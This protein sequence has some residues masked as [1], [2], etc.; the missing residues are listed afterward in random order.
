[1]DSSKTWLWKKKSEKALD[2]N[3]IVKKYLK[4]DCKP[5]KDALSA[6]CKL[7]PAE[8]DCNAKDDLVSIHAKMAEEAI[9]AREVAEGEVLALKRELA[10]ASDAKVAAEERSAQLDAA[11]KQCTDQLSRV[12]EGQEEKLQEA[13]AIKSKAYEGKQKFIEEK[14]VAACRRADALAT[15]NADLRKDLGEKE[16]FIDDLRKSQSQCE[17]E[18]GVLMA[19]VDSTE[20]ENSFLRY[21]FRMLEKELE[22]RSEEREYS[23]ALAEGLQKLQRESVTK[24]TK[25]ESECQ[26]LNALLRKRLQTPVVL[27]K[28][29]SEIEML[30][31]DQNEMSRRR[32]PNPANGAL[33]TRN[34]ILASS[35]EIPSKK[36]AIL[37]ERLCGLEDENKSLQALL[38]HKDGELEDHRIMISRLSTKLSEA[39][40][41]LSSV[42]SMEIVKFSPSSNRFSLSSGCDDKASDSGSW[43]NGPNADEEKLKLKSV[44]E[45][46]MLGVPDMNLMDDFVEMEKLAMVSVDLSAK[47]TGKELV[48]VSQDELSFSE[49]SSAGASSRRSHDWLQDVMK[50]ITEEHRVSKRSIADLLADI[51]IVFGYPKQAASEAP[52]LTSADGSSSLA[53]IKPPPRDTDLS[54]SIQ[55][56]VEVIEGISPPSAAQSSPADNITSADYTH[57]VF[58]WRTSEL[59]AALK[60]FGQ[61]CSDALSGNADLGKFAQE[62]ATAL[63][64]VVTNSAAHQDVLTVR[65]K[66]KKQI[67]WDGIQPE[68]SRL[69]ESSGPKIE[70]TGIERAKKSLDAKLNSVRLDSKTDSSVTQLRESEQNIEQLKIELETLRYSKGMAEDQIEMQKSAN[71]DLATQLT[72]ANTKLNEALQQCS[73]LEMELETKSSSC[74]HLEATCLDLQ[75]QLESSDRKDSAEPNAYPDQPETRTGWEL[76]T[77]SVKLSEA[78]ETILN[79]GRQLKALNSPRDPAVMKRVLSNSFKNKAPGRR[80]SLREQLLAEANHSR[81][82]TQKPPNHQDPETKTQSQALVLVPPTAARHILHDSPLAFIS[83]RNKSGNLAI[84]PSKKKGGGGGFL[85]RLLMRKKKRGGGKTSLTFGSV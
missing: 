54:K 72:V 81:N 22:I 47:F 51:N 24:I 8:C 37:I 52:A 57:R 77:T 65:E 23:R 69:L 42:S 50:A 60:Q 68:N 70:L 40:A 36:A 20:K 48:P 27:T 49:T 38:S 83:P 61:A 79:L 7:A 41:Q 85:G 10:E 82:D 3:E 12:K 13:V 63:E 9:A 31:R 29:K 19:R 18:F 46:K 39:E 53:L 74:E 62:V 45:T 21:E 67:G 43:S 44:Q 78:Q 84:I 4:E 75:L 64:W 2:T 14:F 33:V 35:Q 58:K 6:N 26:R 55:A 71:E 17:A 16:S 56:I 15:Q 1:M 32:K 5:A 28:M 76:A 11:L 30:R 73:S 59:N 66:I 25:L 80:A 34:A